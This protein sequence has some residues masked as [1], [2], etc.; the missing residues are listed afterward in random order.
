M[1]TIFQPSAKVIKHSILRSKRNG[2]T[3]EL[4]TLSGN[5]HRFILSEFNTHRAFSRNSA[6]S[7]AIPTA[8]M[9]E[10]AE[11]ANVEPLSWGENTRGM[12]ATSEVT[13]DVT[14][15]GRACWGE[16]RKF[17]VQCAEYLASLNIHKQV[18]NRILEPFLPHTVVFTTD[19]N[20]LWEFF[21]LRI[22]PH[23]QP[24]IREFAIAVRNA[25]AKSIPQELKPGYLHLPFVD[26]VFHFDEVL[27][28][29]LVEQ[30]QYSSFNREE[31]MYSKPIYNS[32]AMCAR[33]SYLGHEKNQTDE[34]NEKLFWS[35]H[36]NG[37][38]SPFEHIAI[39][40]DADDKEAKEIRQRI[41]G[42]KLPMRQ[43][44]HPSYLQ[45]RKILE[46]ERRGIPML[47]DTLKVA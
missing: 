40:C 41:L 16:S 23:A 30:D 12:S 29:Q 21:N 15:N 25:F 47:A 8:K 44:Y 33:Y 3:R 31:F 5:F 7:R 42:T 19:R 37:H 1:S 20:S 17:A 35:L 38:W 11:T 18:V 22:S 28:K 9:I 6:S 14:A 32:V 36:Q 27:N 4:I 39:A 45:L 13:P 2:S 26:E 24:E 10:L 43:N 34:S 46:K